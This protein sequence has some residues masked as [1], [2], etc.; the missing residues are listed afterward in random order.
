MAETLNIG[1][2]AV[3][4]SN[5]V[6]SWFK[7]DVIDLYDENFKCKKTDQHFKKDKDSD[8]SNEEKKVKVD[9]SES[10]KIKEHT[11]PVDVVFKYTD[12]YS[13]RDILFNT[14]LKSY[15]ST[16]IKPS[17][18]REML[19]SIAKSIDCASISKEWK[20][21]YGYNSTNYELR[22]MLF[23]YNHDGKYHR[24]FYETF[25][26][27][28][29]NERK[30]LGINLKSIGLK[31]GQ[32][33]HIVEPLLISY[34]TTVIADM[35]RLHHEG[36]FPQSEYGFY[37]PELLRN[38]T[39]SGDRYSRPATIEALTAP[40]LIIEHDEV[41][42]K[43]RNGEVIVTE[44]GFVIYY[45]RPGNDPYEFVYLFDTL[46]RYQLLDGERSIRLR[47]AYHNPSQ[48]IG[49]NF[50]QAKDKYIKSWGYDDHKRQILD[51]IKIKE[52]TLME[53]T[54]KTKMVAR[55]N[56]Q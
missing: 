12:P 16:S 52:L 21:R 19:Q 31:K 11:H 18:V 42:T 30:K 47:F 48:D 10:E 49:S 56:E 45:N 5:D 32:Q 33:I 46:S 29:N 6:L 23:I 13:G 27:S 4:I 40:Y 39:V 2:L 50:E 22:G 1:E 51:K 36:T 53:H 37:Y 15:K 25:K 35:N 17:D 41:I 24:N 14:D 55:K 54:F 43:P 9:D 8:D 38:K 3:D 34:M 28:V 20:E 44:P 7:W 26:T